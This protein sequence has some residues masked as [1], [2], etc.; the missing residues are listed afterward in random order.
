[1]GSLKTDDL[2]IVT[3]VLHF[4]SLDSYTTKAK[5]LANSVQRIIQVDCTGCPY[6]YKIKVREDT[7]WVEGVPYSSLMLELL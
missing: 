5:S 7:F 4:Y 3:E 6:P 2:I 1:M